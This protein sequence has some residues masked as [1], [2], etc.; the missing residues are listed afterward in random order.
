MDEMQNP[1]MLLTAK[2]EGR[3]RPGRPRT[4]WLQIVNM[5]AKSM[6]IRKS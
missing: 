3:R 6:E 5:D 4:N 1:R 2:V